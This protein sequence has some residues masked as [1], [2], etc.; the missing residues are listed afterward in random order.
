MKDLLIDAALAFLPLAVAILGG[1]LVWRFF[2]AENALTFMIFV[3][4]GSALRCPTR[5]VA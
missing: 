5:L 3:A 1:A 4:I 2:G